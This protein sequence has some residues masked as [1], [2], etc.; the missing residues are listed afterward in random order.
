MLHLI[1]RHIVKPR[2]LD[3][4][5]RP[6]AFLAGSGRSGT[7]WVEDLIN[8]RH[9]HRII[10]EPFWN[11]KVPFCKAFNGR[12]YLRATN[13]SPQFLAP[14]RRVLSGTFRNEWTD[15]FNTRRVYRYRLIKDIRANL[16]LHWLH[17]HFPDVPIILL[18]RHPVAVTLSRLKQGW[19]M[20]AKPFLDQPEL[21]DDFLAPFAGILAQDHNDFDNLIL[22]WCIENYVPLKQ[23]RP[24]A[25]HLV[26]YEELLRHPEQEIE[27]LFRFLGRPVEPQVFAQL[28]RPSAVT[29]RDSAVHTGNDP[30]NAWRKQVDASQMRRALELLGVFGLDQIYGDDSLPCTQ[31]AQAMLADNAALP[32]KG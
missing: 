16:F 18:L 4:A 22:R 10:F 13:T 32:A 9:D 29:H 8:Y 24:G 17:A 14:A 3:L 28:K 26:F 20:K 2:F 7:T 31:A 23:F 15:K 6:T 12:V 27:R 21:V 5:K 25:V 11:A 1:H 30:V 19:R